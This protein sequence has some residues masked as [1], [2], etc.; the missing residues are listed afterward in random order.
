M[1]HLTLELDTRDDPAALADFGA[2]QAE[3]KMNPD[4]DV[5]ITKVQQPTIRVS[6][7][8]PNDKR[9]PAVL[10]FPGGG[11]G[12]LSMIKE[13]EAVADWLTGLGFVA[14]AVKYRLPYAEAPF[15]VALK[16]AHAAYDALISHQDEWQLDVDRIGVIGFSAGGHLAGSVCNVPFEKQPPPRLSFAGL[17]YP[18]LSM[19]AAIANRGTRLRL[20]GETP[21][22]DAVAEYSL[23]SRVTASTPP[24][25][26]AHAEDDGAVPL[27]HSLRYAEACRKS[28]I[29]VQ[30]AVF[31]SGGHGFGMGGHLPGIDW[32]EQFAAWLRERELI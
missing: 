19:E 7:P 22:D 13:G 10:I 3:E 31:D 16:D 2:E 9:R 17:I 11:Y 14:A 26:L 8:E 24:T 15:F 29:P 27:D 12:G 28:N 21:V 4:R 6:F 25:F 32:P 18:V 30:L 1:E 23:E 5:W 20:L